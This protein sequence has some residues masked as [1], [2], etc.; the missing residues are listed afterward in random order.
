MA[1][2]TTNTNDISNNTA[3]SRTIFT[4]FFVPKSC[5]ITAIEIIPPARPATKYDS[6]SG[7][8]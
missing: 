7:I 6:I 1:E 8:P 5:L 2:T 3:E 4:Y